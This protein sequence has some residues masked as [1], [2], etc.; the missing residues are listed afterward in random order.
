MFLGAIGS[1]L[2]I[3]AIVLLGGVAVPGGQH[4]TGPTK[5][6]TLPDNDKQTSFDNVNVNAWSAGGSD[7]CHAC[8]AD[9]TDCKVDYQPVPCSGW[10]DAS[11]EACGD[12]HFSPGG[13]GECL[14][15]SSSVRA[16]GARSEATSGWNVEYL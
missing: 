14:P 13:S 11:C 7:V 10:R 1:L 8:S 16:E 15:C 6:P 12:F 5:D 2:F 4:G 3:F 9:Q